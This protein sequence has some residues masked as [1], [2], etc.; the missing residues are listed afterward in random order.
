MATYWQGLWAYRSYLLVVSLPI[1]LLPL[2]ILVPTKEAYCAYAIIL[3]ALFWCTEAVPIAVTAFLPLILY[4]MMGIMEA[5]EVSVEYL[6]DTNILFF[7]GLLVAVTIEHWNLHKRIAL[8]VLL[9]IGVRPALLI[10]GFMIVTAF[11]SMWISNTATSAMMVPIAHAVLEQ[12]HNT[13]MGKDIEEGSHNPTFELQEPSPQ[14]EMTELDNG[15]ALPV[16]PAASKLKTHQSNKQ[17]LMTQGLSLSVCYSA[18]IGGIA[19]LTGT[20]PNLVLQGQVNLL[21][22]Q[23]GN[24]VNFATWFSF[25]FPTMVIL[26]LLSWLWLQVLF[27]GFNFRKNFGIGEQAKEQQQA[28]LHIIQTE[29]KLLGPMTFA[30]KAITVLFVILVVLWFT[31]EPGFFPG[32]GE[33]AFPNA[34]G[35]S[36]VSDGTVAMF[37]GLL[38]FFIPSSIPGLTQDPENP[39]K[40]KGPPALLSWKTVNERMPWNIVFLLGGGFALAKGSEQ[41]GLSAWLG[42]KLIQLENVPPSA[43]AFILCLLIAI[44]TEFMSNL[45]TTTL[46]LPIL[47]SMAQAI[48]VH[49]LYVMI[50]C[51]LASSLAFMLPVATTP[52]V[53]V[54]SFGGLKVLDMVRAGF[55]LN[56]IGVLVI[57]LAINS[58]SVP[59]FNLHTFPTWAHSNTST[60]CL[61]SQANST[62][63]RP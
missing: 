61:A 30:E 57:T 20:A 44:F 36:M 32:W 29:H 48:C 54:F 56:I 33:L 11:L 50:P 1:L 51:T 4:P 10:L 6:T 13:H 38:M 60:H 55:M 31:R 5:S 24:V 34:D 53:I 43:I 17:R 28:A 42:D 35:S 19:T 16:S 18:S 22:P 2:P 3:M 47:A 41:S 23:N 25:A 21:F 37:I 52:N 8:C 9:L 58:W 59:I 14:K 49:P 46:F 15:E 40:L 39:R 62:M 12:L 26:L 45:A 27:L 7:G 63:P